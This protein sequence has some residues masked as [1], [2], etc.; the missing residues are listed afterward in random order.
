MR[1]A[2]SDSACCRMNLLAIIVGNFLPLSLSPFFSPSL[3]LFLCL[4]WQSGQASLKE[5]KIKIIKMHNVARLLRERESERKKE[6]QQAK[7][8][9]SARER[10]RER[11]QCCL[12]T[13]R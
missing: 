8:S 4:L 5:I 7:G 9:V 13:A 10:E 2:A 3:C 12:G 6:R 11:A 1:G